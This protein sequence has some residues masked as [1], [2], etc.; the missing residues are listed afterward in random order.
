[1]YLLVF[2][3]YHLPSMPLSLYI[4]ILS[5]LYVYISFRAAL[6]GSWTTY[7]SQSE[8]MN[9]VTLHEDILLGSLLRPGRGRILGIIYLT[10]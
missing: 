3:Y 5:Y 10:M 2:N 9:S 1:M 7:R 6:V 8:T 4:Y